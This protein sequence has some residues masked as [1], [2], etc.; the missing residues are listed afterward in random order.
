MVKKLRS[1]KPRHLDGIQNDKYPLVSN[2]NSDLKGG[3][4]NS[5]K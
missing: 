3:I 4:K 2:E 5:I 1:T